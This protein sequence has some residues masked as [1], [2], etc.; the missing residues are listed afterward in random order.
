M[1]RSFPAAAAR[2]R[3][4]C[5]SAWIVLLAALA[6][7]G[8]FWPDAE[9]R[10]TDHPEPAAIAAADAT[11]RPRANSVASPATP[12][13]GAE[14]ASGSALAETGGRSKTTS[15]LSRLLGLGEG[16]EIGAFGGEEFLDPDVAFV[17]S[18]GALGP[19]AIETHWEIAKG[20]YIY[21]DRIRFQ[22]ADG[23][24]ATLGTAEFPEGKVKD[25]AL[26]HRQRGGTY[27]GVGVMGVLSALIVG[28]CVA[29]PLAGVLIYSR[30]DL[31]LAA[32][33][34]GTAVALK[35]LLRPRSIARNHASGIC[36]QTG[37]APMKSKS[38]PRSAW[39]T[40]SRNSRR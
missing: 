17:L 14:S 29:A 21:R 24:G 10:A 40:V 30:L 25:D 35:V 34:C 28:P 3:E 2:D 5:R 15:A 1:T 38:H 11:L 13:T 23:S 33:D 7:L 8:A 6:A 22:A 32:L 39:V 19:D 20:Y 4:R 26:S 12:A 9:A 27:A 16:I 31:R 37:A 36:G 18:A